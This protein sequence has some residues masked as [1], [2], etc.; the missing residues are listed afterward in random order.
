MTTTT[1]PTMRT[2]AA[3]DLTPG[4]MY[5]LLRDA[6]V[7]RPIAWVST[8]DGEGR[9]NLA[10]YSFFNVCSNEPPV[11]GFAVGPRG[12]DPATG[13]LVEKDT[14]ANIRAT[15][16]LV[17]N[18][19]PEALL[20]P[21]VKTSTSLAPGEDEFAF[22]GLASAPCDIVRAPRVIGAPVAFE[23]ELYEII[24]IGNHH[25]VMGEIV[26]VHLD[27]RIYV[28]HYKG[29]DH[30][31]DPLRVESLRPVGRLGRAYYTR[32]RDLETVL[33]TDGPND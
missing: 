1:N 30:R 18:I 25:W 5:L 29:L 7:P 14:L 20:V 4:E 2:L 8:V 22:A 17:V 9:C 26:R 3:T 6:V 31:V 15:R 33:R 28:G 11:L 24:V 10:P 13:A 23:C 27:E 32:L 12:R 19:V 21:M 16:E